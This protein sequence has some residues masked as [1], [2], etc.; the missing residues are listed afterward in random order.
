MKNKL[1]KLLVAA[2][3]V[4]TVFSVTACGPNTQ[5]GGK[6]R[7]QIEFRANISVL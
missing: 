5:G 3:S 7:V 2:M 1:I 6:D 4:V